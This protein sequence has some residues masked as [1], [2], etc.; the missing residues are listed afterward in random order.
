MSENPYLSGNF[1]PVQEETTAFDLKVRGTIPR[2]LCGRLLRI[3]PN[4][5]DP[6]PATHHWFIGS[7]LVHGLKLEDGHARWYRSRFVRDD[8]VVRLRG[9][10]PVPGP[11]HGGPGSGAVNTNVIGFAGRTFAIVEAG[12]RPMELGYELETLRRS[13]FDG[14]LK[15]GFTAH[16]KVDP[17]TGEAH[18]AV[19]SPFDENVQYVVVAKDGKVRRSVDIHLP[20]KPMIHD[21]AI[22]ENHFLVLD[23]PCV[24]DGQALLDGIPLP[25]RWHPEIPARVGVLPREGSARDIVWCEVDPCYVFHPMN[26]YEEP[27]GRIVLDVARHPAMFATDALGPNEGPPVLERWRIDPKGGPVKTERVDDRAQ[28]FPRVDERLVGRPYRFGYVAELGDS[29]AAPGLLKHDMR[30]GTAISHREG[31]DRTFLEPVFVPSHAG[32]GEDEGFVLA[33]VHDAKRNAADV[34]ILDAQDF[35]A[36]PIATIELPARVPY[37]FHGNWV[38]DD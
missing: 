20:H 36:P 3:G 21:C 37:G 22:T 19:Y 16:P 11:E 2:S 5:L 4:P 8:D 32:A 34:V 23:L 17:A 24:F 14:S 9:G 38:A 35:A 6:D 25:Y 15:G 10:D 26:A 27:D 30:S 33:Y 18:A 28:E 1:A 13:D 12:S 7:G 29:F 31:S